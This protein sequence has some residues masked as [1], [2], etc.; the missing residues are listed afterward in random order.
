LA[1]RLVCST[2]CST[3]IAAV[4]GE[5]GP[6]LAWCCS[7]RRRCGGGDPGRQTAAT[8]SAPGT[9]AQEL[10][11]LGEDGGGNLGASTSSAALARPAELAGAVLAVLALDPG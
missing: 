7:R 6:D 10:G 9:V 2:A 11:Q 5:P 4:V 1:R 8:S 3:G